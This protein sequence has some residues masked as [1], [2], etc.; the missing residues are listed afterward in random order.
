LFV[1]LQ[2]NFINQIL[3]KGI[4]IKSTGSSVLVRLPDGTR[5][6]SKVKGTFRIKEIRA[7]NPVSVGDRVVIDLMKD[8]TGIIRDIEERHNYIVRKATKLS[9]VSHIIGANLDQ[10]I[11][12]ASLALPRTS[13]GF[14]DRFLVVAEAYH[15]PAAIVFNKLDLYKDKEKG[16]LEELLRIYRD[17]GYESNAVSA[18]TGEGT[19][20]LRE[21]L[22]NKTSLLTGHSGVG[23]STL[24]NFLQP[25][26]NLKT[27]Q[28]SGW[29][30]KGQH[31]T[32]FAEMHELSFGGFIID[33]PGIREFGLVDFEKTEVAERF[34]EMRKYMNDC[35]Y[36]NCT[37]THEP[38]CAV[39]TAL[40]NGLI[41]RSRYEN[42]L[43]IYYGD[44]WDEK[45]WD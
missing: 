3:L 28:V 35:R 36:H 13:S 4:V 31:V 5:I 9:K 30:G 38:D 26:L 23:K 39:K 7:T 22:K 37:H 32:T 27:K 8:G 15:I 29:S 33:T 2:K 41:S 20:W 25:G 6:Q 19:E 34:P 42:Y 40:E 14:I 16:R 44:D 11:L 43:K 10:A 21:I 17:A 24:I 12:V 45:E 18:L 1:I